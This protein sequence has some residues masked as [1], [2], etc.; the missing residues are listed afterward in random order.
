MVGIYKDGLVAYLKM[1][2]QQASAS[3]DMQGRFANTLIDKL[4]DQANTTLHM[5]IQAKDIQAPTA[6]EQGAITDLPYTT[7]LDSLNDTIVVENPL[8]PA[9]DQGT[10][11]IT[12][13]DLKSK[14]AFDDLAHKL[15]VSKGGK[16]IA[17]GDFKNDTFC[18]IIRA[19][20]ARA[21]SYLYRRGTTVDKAYVQLVKDLAAMYNCKVEGA[22]TGAGGA[23]QPASYQSG[24]TLSGPALQ[25]VT[26]LISNMP[27]S[28]DRIDF[29][30]IGRW[31]QSYASMGT[32]VHIS[33]ETI[34]AINQAQEL[35]NTIRTTYGMTTQSLSDEVMAIAN[36]V[37]SRSR[38]STAQKAAAPLNYLH[39]LQ[40]LMGEVG[41]IL[42]D[43]KSNVYDD[44]G[45]AKDY[46][47]DLD[48][49]IG[50]GGS[51][52][53]NLNM[54]KINGWLSDLPS[55]IQQLRTQGF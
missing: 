28:G 8:T 20:Y 6:Q 46:Q 54:D 27:L 37:G 52:F 29:L 41:N 5:G 36:T 14:M 11:I 35:L 15:K 16:V 13:K 38:G 24:K 12:P 19:L 50:A 25:A 44:L 47:D 53:Y 34:A 55:A 26:Q 49:Q 39:L 32:S 1:L 51:S 43:F 7:S 30:R 33:G 9:R 21:Y 17:Y 4:I 31:L 22:E 40:Q 3:G 2:Q 23:M 48:E 18:D 42:T 45:G 10:I